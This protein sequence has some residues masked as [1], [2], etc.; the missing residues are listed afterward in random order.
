MKFKQISY[1]KKWPFIFLFI[2]CFIFAKCRK[3]PPLP[4]FYFRCNVNGQE[5]LPN[6]CANCTQSDLLG[7]TVLILRGNRGFETLGI[8]IKEITGIKAQT[9]ILNEKNGRRGDYKNGTL[10]NDRY[11]TDAT[12]TGI[13]EISLLDK[14]SKIIQG[15]FHFKAFNEFRNDSVNITDGKFR[16]RYNDH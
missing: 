7:D 1:L 11:F 14:T 4:A 10:T 5:Y 16:L 9:Y 2:F 15:T 12:R 3:D 6:N 8:G 13:L